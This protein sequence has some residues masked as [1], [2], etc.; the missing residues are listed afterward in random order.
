LGMACTS[1]SNDLITRNAEESY[2]SYEN[3]KSDLVTFLDGVV[4]QFEHIVI[5]SFDVAVKEI[6]IILDER[7]VRLAGPVQDY[8]N[9]TVDPVLASFD[10]LSQ[11]MD[12]TRELLSDVNATLVELKD[13][14]TILEQALENVATSLN[15]TVAGCILDPCTKILESLEKLTLGMDLES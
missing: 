8:L 1:L 9:K 13:N 10:S 12:L 4:G 5:D 15:S 11:Q 6:T 14:S 7:G 3:I 2:N